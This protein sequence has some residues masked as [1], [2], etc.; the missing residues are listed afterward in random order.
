MLPYHFI[1]D[2]SLPTE[3][4]RWSTAPHFWGCMCSLQTSLVSR[5]QLDEERSAVSFHPDHLLQTHHREAAEKQHLQGLR[6]EVAADG[7]EDGRDHH[8]DFTPT[9]HGLFSLLPTGKFC[10]T[11]T[12]TG[13][14]CNN[15]FTKQSQGTYRLFTL[16]G[17]LKMLLHHFWAFNVWYCLY[18]RRRRLLFLLSHCFLR[19]QMIHIICSNGWISSPRLKRPQITS[20]ILLKF[21]V[22]MTTK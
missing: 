2:S 18:F 19:A 21:N 9:S 13:R 6:Q 14:L 1:L 7:G 16:I 4:W 11:K 3:L 12:G 15:W 5:T 17:L 10:S 22:L 8:R 20:F